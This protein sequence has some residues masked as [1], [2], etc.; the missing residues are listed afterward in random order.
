MDAS[1]LLALIR[2]STDHID[3]NATHHEVLKDGLISVLPRITDC[4]ELQ[5]LTWATWMRAGQAPFLSLEQWFDIG[6]RIFISKLRVSEPRLDIASFYKAWD[7][8]VT[9]VRSINGTINSTGE[10]SASLA[11]IAILA[12]IL[13]TEAYCQ[14]LN[15]MFH[16]DGLRKA[17]KY[18][19]TWRRELILP[20]FA[21]YLSR[22]NT[23]GL[24]PLYFVIAEPADHLNNVAP[25]TLI[26]Q[27][28]PII[29]DYVISNGAGNGT[30]N[31][32][33]GRCARTM[34]W[35]IPRC[36]SHQTIASTLNLLCSCAF[37]LSIREWNDPRGS[38]L[39]DPTYPNTLL[40]YLLIFKGV[41]S[42]TRT[43]P[44]FYLLMVMSL[45]HLHF[46]SLDMGTE[47]FELYEDVYYTCCIAIRERPILISQI[48]GIMGNNIWAQDESKIN[49]SKI[50]FLFHFIENQA[51]SI[52]LLTVKN[53]VMHYRKQY[54]GSHDQE[55]IEGLFSM[56]L[57]VYT[58]EVDSKGI[59]E[60]QWAN[61]NEFAEFVIAYYSN[62]KLLQSSQIVLIFESIGVK[63]ASWGPAGGEHMRQVLHLLYL[64]IV[65]H[66]SD[67][68]V[69]FTLS[70]CLATL[71]RFLLPGLMIDWLENVKELK[72]RELHLTAT[73]KK[74]LDKILWNSI[75]K[76]KDPRLLTWWYDH[77]T[78]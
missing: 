26:L 49:N 1:Y 48:I 58:T 5:Q 8:T 55:I 54:I 3:D 24:L 46:I 29:C 76:K 65:S 7:A 45:F 37:N 63:I 42:S 16:L 17:L 9:R 53:V 72:D 40:T 30:L 73:Q 67:T 6:S 27:F 68:T 57:A 28:T 74:E 10:W 11:Q 36:R 2:G 44:E 43:R 32:H 75:C 78:S 41:C 19:S 33:L 69:A 56:L 13:S 31:N 35:L 34:S 62:S 59:L 25:D 50:I 4:D 14:Q 71:M 51:E 39:G 20:Q 64:Q 15:K 47:G 38:Y 77:M 61:I 52:S 18:Y 23:N 70:E 21:F 12:G 22:P 66:K 60:W